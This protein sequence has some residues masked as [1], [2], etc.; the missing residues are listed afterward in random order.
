MSG[1]SAGQKRIGGVVP[2][3]L[4]AWCSVPIT[5]YET[6]WAAKTTRTVAQALVTGCG[7]QKMVKT[8]RRLGKTASE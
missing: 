3:G 6:R 7:G 1:N 5:A 4:T 8:C 2:K